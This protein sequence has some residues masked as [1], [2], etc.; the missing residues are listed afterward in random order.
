VEKRWCGNYDRG[1]GRCRVPITE[2]QPS[3]A[4]L[5]AQNTGKEQVGIVLTEP[6]AIRNFLLMVDP[7]RLSSGN[8]PEKIV[9]T[10]NITVSFYKCTAGCKSNQ[11]QCSCYK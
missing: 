2:D 10:E 3:E 8:I 1:T 11:K 5:V 6:N 7:G 4:E 9:V